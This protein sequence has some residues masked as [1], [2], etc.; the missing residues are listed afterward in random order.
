MANVDIIID[1]SKLVERDGVLYR[2]LS[3]GIEEKVAWDS[4][5]KDFRNTDLPRAENIVSLRRDRYFNK[6]GLDVDFLFNSY[7][8]SPTEK[9]LTQMILEE[10]NNLGVEFENVSTSTDTFTKTMNINIK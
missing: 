6:T 3:N 2:K 4:L 10:F 7:F 1:E 9:Q 8:S 5:I